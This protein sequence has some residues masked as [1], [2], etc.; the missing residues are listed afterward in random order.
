MIGL[1]EYALTYIAE[2]LGADVAVQLEDFLRFGESPLTTAKAH[3]ESVRQALMLWSARA[4]NTEVTGVR[5][6]GVQ[7]L[8]RS[9]RSLD[10]EAV[11]ERYDLQDGRALLTCYREKDTKLPVGYQFVNTP[12][13]SHMDSLYEDLGISLTPSQRSSGHPIRIT[14]TTPAETERSGDKERLRRA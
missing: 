3:P 10:P 7:E 6:E 4:A 13:P 11:L 1:S 12:R 2:G 9:L 8:V 14:R 5:I